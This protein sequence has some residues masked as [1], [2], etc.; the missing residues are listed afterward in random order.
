MAKMSCEHTSLISSSP[1]LGLHS[2]KQKPKQ[3]NKQKG[4]V[5]QT[6][7]GEFRYT[8]HRQSAG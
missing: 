1:I 8:V 4:V 7:V 2:I 3:A 6:E 5:A